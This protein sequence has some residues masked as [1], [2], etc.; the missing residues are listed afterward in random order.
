MDKAFSEIA[1]GSVFQFNNVQYT[2]TNDIRV[3]C[4]KV[5][6]AHE[7]SNKNNTTYIPPTTIVSTM[8]G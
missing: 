6:N 5:I 8:N 2:K 4:C 7:T 3:S 1:V